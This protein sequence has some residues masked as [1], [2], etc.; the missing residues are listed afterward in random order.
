VSE[1]TRSDVVPTSGSGAVVVLAGGTGGAKLAR[2]MLDVVGPDELVVIANTGDDIDIYGSHVSPDPDLVS[3]WLADLINER[4]WGIEGDTFAVMDALRALGTDVWFNLGDRDLAWCLERRR[5]EDEGLRHTEALARLNGA[6]E[7]RARVLPM[8][9]EPLRTHIRTDAGWRDF[10]QFMIGDRAEGAVLE[11]AFA[12]PAQARLVKPAVP[13]APPIAPPLT[14]GPGGVAHDTL[15]PPASASPPADSAPQPTPEILAA[16]ATA[17][18]VIVGPSNPVI[19]IWPIL[20][21]LGRVLVAL[22]APVVCVSPI[23]DGEVVKGPTAAFLAAYDQPA[24]AA[25]VAA[26]YEKVA[27]GLLDGIVT[28]DPVDGLATLEIDTNMPDAQGRARVAEQT[29]AF[30]ESL[31]G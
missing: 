15:I 18:T 1:R 16:L 14:A 27:P 3:F 12:A 25:G 7:V 30:A 19:S 8:C 4:G 29:L 17:R 22:D 31:S 24:S 9:D 2:G 13:H 6:I 5:M 26:F 10:Q 28:D 21:V 23:V 20:H 11:V